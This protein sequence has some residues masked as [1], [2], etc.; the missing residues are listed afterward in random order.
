MV[1]FICIDYDTEENGKKEKKWWR[2]RPPIVRVKGSSLPRQDFFYMANA[3]NTVTS[4]EKWI[5]LV[6]NNTILFTLVLQ[7]RPESTIIPALFWDL[8]RIYCLST[9]LCVFQ[10]YFSVLLLRL[11]LYYIITHEI[12]CK[13]YLYLP[14]S[15]TKIIDWFK[16]CLTRGLSIYF[17]FRA[18]K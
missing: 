13:L 16:L 12:S 11:L 1:E 15:T 10:F 4:H 14:N 6:W 18:L 7:F 2:I 3:F 17:R 9:E 5:R 8:S